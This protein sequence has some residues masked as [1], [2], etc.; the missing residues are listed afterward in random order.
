MCVC[1]RGV[2]G[3]GARG[4]AGLRVAGDFQEH[5]AREPVGGGSS[6][7]RLDLERVDFG[8]VYGDDDVRNR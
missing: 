4:G 5:R 1:M 7:H 2:K 8:A 3:S 6:I